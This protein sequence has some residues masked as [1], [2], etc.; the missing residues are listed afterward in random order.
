MADQLGTDNVRAYLAGRGVLPASTAEVSEFPGGVSGVTLLVDTGQQRLVVKQALSRL[1]VEKDWRSDPRRAVVEARALL[2]YSRITP[3]AT[4]TL[5]DVDPER[6]AFTMSAAPDG[7]GT[8]K[9]QLLAGDVDVSVAT[10]V[11]SILG[12]W[13]AATA[14]ADE[15]GGFSDRTWFEE[16]RVAPFYRAVMLARPDLADAVAERLRCMLEEESQVLVH[17]DFSPKNVLVK[18]DGGVW[19]VDFEVAHRGDPVFDLAFLVHHLLLKAVHLPMYGG[20]LLECARAALAA[21]HAVPGAADIEHQHLMG[22]IGCLT[23][24]RVLGTSPASYLTAEERDIA[25]AIGS[26]L[27]AHPSRDLQEAWPSHERTA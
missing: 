16:L 2:A 25:E 21:Y 3:E 10:A 18:P 7:T 26:E 17:G 23:L 22:H 14:G 5:V 1:R 11:G 9:Q 20:R 4:P 24:A 8:W 15:A 27:V 6:C 19:I 13:H 12:R